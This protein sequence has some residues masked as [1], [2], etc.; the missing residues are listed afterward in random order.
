[1]Q[2]RIL[3]NHDSWHWRQSLSSSAQSSPWYA[4]T[5][6]SNVEN[7][8]PRSRAFTIWNRK[9]SPGYCKEDG[10]T[11][12]YEPPSENSL[13]NGWHG[14]RHCHGA[15]GCPSVQSSWALFSQFLESLWEGNCGVPLCSHCPLMLKW[16]CCHMTTCN[17]ESEHHF[18]PNTFC[19][20]HFDRSIIIREHPDRRVTLCFWITLVNPGL[21]TCNDFRI[22]ARVPVVVES[23]KHFTAT[24]PLE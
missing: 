9:K 1:M 15:T 3:L 5:A 16:H 23:P 24:I 19:S 8:I 6:S 7:R 17:K 21:V 14:Q 13:S 20:I 4:A 10:T 2:R 11:A 18:L 22:V 12:A